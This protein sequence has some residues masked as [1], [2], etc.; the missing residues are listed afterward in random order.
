MSDRLRQHV[1]RSGDGF[2]NGKLSRQAAETHSEKRKAS[3]KSDNGVS[4]SFVPLDESSVR[5]KKPR[6]DNDDDDNNDVG[7]TESGS[8][9]SEDL[10]Q[11]KVGMKVNQQLQN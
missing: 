9:V 6:F 10:L 5:R 2:D 4:E 11:G 3:V 8:N 1:S 7:D